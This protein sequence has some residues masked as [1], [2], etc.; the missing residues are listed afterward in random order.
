MKNLAF[1]I[2]LLVIAFSSQLSGQW[3]TNGNHIYNT[4]SGNVGIGNNTPATLLHVQ[5]NT[6]EPTITIQNLGGTG[7]AT[8][9]MM[10]NV[11]G[12][13]W[14]FKATNS[15]GFKIRDQ[16]NFMDV[17]VIEAGSFSN[18]IYIKST[19][20][21]GIGT[22]AP[23][24]SALVDMSSA[25]KG[26]LP[27]RL[28]SEQMAAI[29][30]P[31]EGLMI[32]NVSDK[33]FYFYTTEWTRIAMENEGNWT[34]GSSITITHNAGSV[35]PVSKVVTYGTLTNVPG[36]PAKCWIASNLGSD[37]QATSVDDATE[38]SAG[39]YWQF[40]R[41][42]GYKHDGTIRTP[43]TTWLNFSENSNWSLANDPC[44]LELGS[45]WRLPTITEW[46]NVD[47]SGG[48][49]NWN[50]PWNSLLKLH[51]AGI[52]NLSD[53]V[54][55]YRGIRGYFWSNSQYNSGD[56]WNIYFNNGFC[57]SVFYTKTFGFTLRCLKD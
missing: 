57:E 5:K 41:M 12:A 10:D 21:I 18:A 28:N 11:S 45:G 47:A 3:A 14:K 1:L 56:G 43:N 40:N 29:V 2:I 6:T 15:G 24:N 23:D 7:G 36:E 19:D 20:N 17:I 4:N 26:F 53:G 55:N 32:Y 27:P 52:L 37:H 44:N 51:A 38:A 48:W 13:N 49:T 42:Q 33:H 16:A 50:G 30:N 39:W 9:T 46:T 31:A 25:N 34:C 8:Y 54:L 35:A 22:S